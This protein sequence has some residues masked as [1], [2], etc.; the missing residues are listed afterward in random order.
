MEKKWNL[1]DIKP[2]EKRRPTNRAPMRVSDA[3]R[4]ADNAGGRN[5]RQKS[6]R[7]RSSRKNLVLIL[8]AVLL[9]GTGGV[10][11]AAFTGKTEVTVF[12]R[13]REPTVNA[14]FEADRNATSSNLAFEVMTLE[15]EAEREVEAS[16]QEEVEE[17]AT[18]NLTIYKTT[19]GEERLIKNTRFESPNGLIFKITE[20]AVIPGGTEEV[21]GSVSVEVF[22][23]APGPE[24]NLDAGTRF[25][26]PGFEE[27]D[28][29]ELYEAVY[30][31]N[32]APITGGHSG[33]Q[34]I[35]EDSEL[36]AAT[37]SLR[38]ELREAL[39]E[40]VD[41][42][43]PAGF[44]AYD[45]AVRFS[46]QELPAEEVGDGRVR[47]KEKAVLHLPLFSNETF[48]SFIAAA[49]IPGYE[50]GLVRLEDPSVLDFEYSSEPEFPAGESFSFKLLGRP[51]IIW[52][53]DAE[54]LK[55]D[56]S[57]GS[58][59][60]LN[61]VLGGYPAIEKATATIR[62]FWKRSFPTDPADIEIV[63]TLNEGG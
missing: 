47:I 21:P 17:Q 5:T 18:G 61:T 57:G 39:L 25:T 54:R 37:E 10:A 6:S 31:E 23:D 50:D 58:Q 49:T 38:S 60:A 40:R 48:A 32:P 15:A 44:A 14:I 20:S 24:Y 8:L 19:S 51:K 41:S 45:E 30:A 4:P 28:L 59:T 43:K 11:F 33:P 26:V 3:Q 29:M 46:Y 12:P 36:E 7:S 27:S 53:Y 42:Q 34:F 52:T 35:I 13:W 1:Q 63:E 56:L 2:A 62:P 55:E 22:A 16:G 9:L